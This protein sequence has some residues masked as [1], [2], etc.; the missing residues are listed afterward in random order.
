MKFFRKKILSTILFSSLCMTGG[1]LL[2]SCESV[3]DEGGECN[4]EYYV[5]YIYD[6]NMKFADAF[7]AQV[8][9]V[10]LY[11]FD[12]NGDFVKKFSESGAALAQEGYLMPIDLQPGTYHFTAWCGLQNNN[13]HFTIA[14][15]ISKSEHPK[16]TMARSHD[17]DGT[18]YQDQNL[19]ALYHG[20]IDASLPDDNNQHIYT[21]YLTKDTNNINVTLSNTGGTPLSKSDFTF[22]MKDVN[23]SLDHDNSL[24]EDEEITYRPW[25]Y[26]DF[27]SE[28]IN[29][30]ASMIGD[31]N[32]D[33]NNFVQAE[34]ASSRLTTGTDPIV[35]I[36]DNKTGKTIFSLPVTQFALKY[37]SA[38]HSYMEDQEYLD[39]ED[40]YDFTVFLAE[41]G[42]DDDKVSWTAVSVTINGWHVI[43]NGQTDF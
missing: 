30:R 35:D 8:S 21:V 12:E 37:K 10:D 2:P 40:E 31:G 36:V 1:G 13:G 26:R 7:S 6:L 25:H 27:E 11:V 38:N 23:G 32:V 20:T 22:T 4:P 28:Y 3:W 42:D 5:Q 33:L 14:D 29:S 16:V 9:S 15:E 34:F 19:Y 18:T 43:E 39:R 17:A 41:S 24:L